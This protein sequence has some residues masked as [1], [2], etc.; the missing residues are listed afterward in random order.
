[1]TRLGKRNIVHLTDDEIKAN[2]RAYKAR[3]K[4]PALIKI[5]CECP[6]CGCLHY[7]MDAPP[8]PR[9]MPLKR[10]C[11]SCANFADDDYYTEYSV[12]LY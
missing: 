8:L 9:I 10:F 4:L 5:N 3:F 7:I 11:K 12:R 2:K 1:M 6:G